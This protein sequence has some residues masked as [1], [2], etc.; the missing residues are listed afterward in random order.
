MLFN[1]LMRVT[2]LKLRCWHIIEPIG[3]SL[4]YVTIRELL[5]KITHQWWIWKEKLEAKKEAIK[6]A[7]KYLE[8][9]EK[10]Y[11]KDNGKSKMLA[12]DKSKK[13]LE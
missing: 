8:H 11:K 3:L 12:V 9:A 1:Y 2:M 5:R 13:V 6:V 10:A 7:E 4:F